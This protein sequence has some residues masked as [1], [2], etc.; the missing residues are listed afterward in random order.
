MGYER[1]SQPGLTRPQSLSSAAQSGR[2]NFCCLRL[3]RTGSQ[4]LG[5]GGVSPV[6]SPS[7]AVIFS[8]G[9]YPLPSPPC[10]SAF[11]GPQASCAGG[12]GDLR[13]SCFGR[14]T[15]GGVSSQ[16]RCH[17]RWGPGDCGSPTQSR[18]Q[19]CRDLHTSAYICICMS[20][21]P[22]SS[23]RACSVARTGPTALGAQ[24]PPT[25]T[26]LGWALTQ[27]LCQLLAHPTS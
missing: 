21:N 18:L 8:V 2:W 12:W 14:E 11:S 4:E 22:A 16:R 17:L 15:Q 10:D 19:S 24:G 13:R 27:R 5:G 1:P 9:P 25:A 3:S 23:F 20:P 6:L 26:A 7:D